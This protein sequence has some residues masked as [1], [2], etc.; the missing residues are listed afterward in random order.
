[1]IK[2]NG[3]ENKRARIEILSG[4]TRTQLLNVLSVL[5]E[6]NVDRII[7]TCDIAI[8]KKQ[9]TIILQSLWQVHNI[10]SL[11]INDKIKFEAMNKYKS[12][13]EYDATK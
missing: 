5:S 11:W 12:L 7:V 10:Y 13:I 3:I 8:S 1:M 6:N 2:I 4:W 9:A